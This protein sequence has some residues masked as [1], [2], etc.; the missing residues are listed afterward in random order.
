MCIQ[1]YQIVDVA[2]WQVEGP[3]ATGGGEKVWLIESNGETRWLFKP[4]KLHVKDDAEWSQGDD[5]AEKVAEQLAGILEVPSAGI[6]MAVRG[7]VAGCISRNLKPEQWELQNGVILLS[8]MLGDYIPGSE[9]GKKVVDGMVR[10]GHSLENIRKAV[11]GY[12]SPPSNALPEDFGAFDVFVGYIVFDAL[13]ANQD[14]HDENWAIMRSFHGGDS[15]KLAGSFD[16][17]RAFG[18]N[19]LECRM[20]SILNNSDGILRWVEKGV[21][22][23]FE[24]DAMVGPVTLIDL[25]LQALWMVSQSVRE[26]WIAR[27]EGMTGDVVDSIVKRVPAISEV[28]RDFVTR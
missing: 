20:V 13:I 18:S 3:E 22:Q 4:N 25:A 23:R 15:G 1:E 11:G 14:R 10:K 2:D 28:Q 9:V 17:A 26:H 19:L 24:Y 8:E 27:V 6:E 7:K 16:H 12:L 5:I 21:A